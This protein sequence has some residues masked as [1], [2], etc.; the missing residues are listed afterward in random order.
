MNYVV[1][2]RGTDGAQREVEV[3]AA[4]RSGCMAECRRRGITPLRTR[5]GARGLGG[6]RN[7]QGIKAAQG[8]VAFLAIAV[9][10]LAVGVWWLAGH[11]AGDDVP[12]QAP[13]KRNAGAN[14]NGTQQMPVAPKR[15]GTAKPSSGKLPKAEAARPLPPMGE[16]AQDDATVVSNYV[17]THY[18]TNSAVRPIDPNDPD[19]PLITG[20]N[21][22]LGSL[23]STELGDPVPPFPY[24]FHVEEV[25]DQNDQFLK[26]LKHA[27]KLRESDSP[28]RVETKQK[29]LQA[30]LDL[31]DAMDQG[32]TVRDAI[33][34]AYIQR[35][36]AYE[37]RC[38]Y[39]EDLRDWAQEN[40]NADEFKR[41]MEETNKRL[42]EKGIKKITLDDL[43][44]EGLYEA[45]GASQQEEERK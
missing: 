25:N 16:M 31:L 37:A 23:M 44:V 19:L 26:S 38:A 12:R 1:T 14:R 6:G 8:K 9:L 30:R 35:V 40:P 17:A 20:V 3:E 11:R 41:G 2:Y 27:V 10:A 34:A 39:I 33:K 36:R 21:Q 28:E 13:A 42:S 18:S 45:D 15:G 22:E 5:A 4:D 7:G 29:L 43:G 24:S 32:M